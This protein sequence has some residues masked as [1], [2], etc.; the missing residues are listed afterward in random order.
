MT[1]NPMF[2]L[3]TLDTFYSDSISSSSQISHAISSASLV[4]GFLIAFPLLFSHRVTLIEDHEQ[5]GERKP[6]CS[7]TLHGHYPWI[8]NYINE[9]T[10]F[11][12]AFQYF[13]PLLLISYAYTRMGIKLW[14]SEMPGNAQGSRDA[15]ILKNKVKEYT[16]FTVAFQYFIPLLLISYA[17][18]R[19]GIKLWGSEMP[20]NAQGSRDA[21]ILKNKV[22]V[23]RTGNAQGSRDAIILKNKVKVIKML[24][25]VV[26]TFAVCWLPLQT[27]K[28]VMGIYPQVNG[29]FSISTSTSAEGRLYKWNGTLNKWNGMLYKWNGRLYKW[30]GRGCANRMSEAVQ[31]EWKAVQMEWKAVRMEWKAVQMEWEAVQMEWKAVQMEWKAVQ[32]EW[33]AVQ[34]EW[35][36]VQMEWKAVQM[37]WKA[38]QMEWKAVQME[39]KAVQMDGKLYKWNGRLYK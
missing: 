4:L 15:I 3:D 17:Y 6:Y 38:V 21:I 25:I 28:I 27:Y 2:R 35:K 18:T 34:M 29:T 5:P 39:W 16:Y 37:E 20:G 24:I 36:A 7:P 9:Y 8:T 11:T 26:A 12:V 32:M 14:G 22:K 31:M 13:I 19:M 23:R 33:K 10:Y 1:G 30:N